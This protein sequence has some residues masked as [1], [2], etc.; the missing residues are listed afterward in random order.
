M[1]NTDDHLKKTNR[2]GDLN[3]QTDKI[4][5]GSDEMILC[6]KCRKPNPPNRASCLYCAA[7]IDGVAGD[8][9]QLKLNR[10][11]LENWENGF[12]V[13]FVPPAPDAD[14]AAAARYLKI[15]HEIFSHMASA[16]EPF[17]LARLESEAESEIASAQLSKCGLRTSIV[18]DVKLKVGKPCSRLRSV[19]FEGGS[20]TF[21]SFN[22]NERS[23]IAVGDVVLIVVGRVVESSVESVEKGR[24]EKR[25]LLSETAASSDELLIDV[26]ANAV[27]PG[28]RITTKGFDFSTLGEEKS[29]LAVDNIA[30]LFEKLKACAAN[31]KVIEEYPRIIQPLSEVWDIERRTDFDGMKRTGV[32]SSGF[33]SVVRTSNL[34]QFSKYSRLQRLLV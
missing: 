23:E 24:K 32:W 9:S 16:T 17:P 29:L 27:E 33:S 31:A 6:G 21:T 4:A 18:S 2:I 5:F 25:K 3:I 28:W 8:S 10:R 22:T 26:Y 30:L 13:V 12:N 1:P 15:D 7:A 14:V 34:E 11:K 20:V 19:E